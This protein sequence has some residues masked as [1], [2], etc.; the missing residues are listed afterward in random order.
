MAAVLRL[1]LFGAGRIGQFHAATIGR[2]T[3]G[4]E[5]GAIVDAI[6]EAA[7]RLAATTGAARWGSDPEVILGD[8]AIDA[9]KMAIIS[10]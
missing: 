8:P 7:E 1:G 9:V 10:S 4:V 3:A 5:L 2:K 6:P